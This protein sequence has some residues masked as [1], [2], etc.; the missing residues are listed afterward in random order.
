MNAMHE[1][2]SRSV[3][4]STRET[5]H[6]D[7]A[8][9]PLQETS[10]RA[11]TAALSALTSPTPAMIE[12]GRR[13]AREHRPFIGTNES[14]ALTSKCQSCPWMHDPSGKTDAPTQGESH[15]VEASFVAMIETAER[16][17]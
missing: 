12:A 9:L 2:V 4:E 13:A 8:I 1:A 5:I 16:K 11:A 15:Q 6:W 3:H 14:G 10:R 17:L 7:R